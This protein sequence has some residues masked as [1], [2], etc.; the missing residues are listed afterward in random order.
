MEAN[1]RK[2]LD[3]SWLF[4]IALLVFGA[5]YRVIR[6]EFQPELP[7]F[8]PVMAIAFCGAL[9]LPGRM[10]FLVALPALFVSDLILNW[11]YG[12]PLVDA[13]MIPIYACYGFAIWMGYLMRGRNLTWI[14]SATLLNALV[15][16]FV[17][18]TM[19]WQSL[20]YARTLAG[21]F[22]A[23]TVG[24]PGYPPT[25]TFFRNSAFGDFLFTGLFLGSF[26]AAKKRKAAPK[27]ARQE[28]SE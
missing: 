1:D 27:R 9:F 3:P 13:G 19:A 2:P 12:V 28:A 20:P 21:W 14:V 15:F 11:H 16:Y 24:L 26:Y 18:N 8:S 17:T 10:V 6:L 4:L 23:V 22:Q 5:F 7:N 25:W